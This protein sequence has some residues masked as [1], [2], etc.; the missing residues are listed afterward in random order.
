MNV[1]TA[2]EAAKRLF[3]EV[4]VLHRMIL[5]GINMG[6]TP[7]AM[8]V[9]VKR[10]FAHLTADQFEEVH[11]EL[12]EMNCVLHSRKRPGRYMSDYNVAFMAVLIRR[13]NLKHYTAEPINRGTF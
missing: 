12:S 10:R 11:Y 3:E 13:R 8:E 9:L 4:E 5:N 1:K 6:A 7:E 2:E